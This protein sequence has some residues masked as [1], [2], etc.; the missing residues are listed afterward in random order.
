MNIGEILTTVPNA[1]TYDAYARL[2]N[3]LK[4]YKSPLC[5]ISGGSDSDIMLHLCATLDDEK[6][7]RYVFFDTG[8]EFQATKDHIKD[9]E[10]RYG[11]TIETH[12]AKMPVPLCTKKYGV[13]FLSKR[14]SDYIERLQRHN[15]Q[16]ED[17]DFETLYARY[18]K[19]KAPLRWWCNAFGENS[20]FNISHNKWLKEFMV[21]N[22]PTFAISNKCC[23]YAKKETAQD[24][25]KESDADL[26]IVGIRKSE[27]GARAVA[28]K[29]CYSPETEKHI[30]EFRPIFWFKNETKEAFKQC[31]EIKNSDCYEKW[32]LRRTGCSGCPFARDIETEINAVKMYE[33]KLYKA[34]MNVFGASYEYTKAYRQFQKEKQN[35]QS[36]SA[37]SPD[38]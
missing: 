7:I 26:N 17:E 22:P 19:C 3:K 9:L 11:I 5:S 32:G 1:E 27:G 38:S 10:Q 16:W 31:Y 8:L 12:R 15:F 33:P 34:L 37:G 28:Y 35:E 6:K 4:K 13:P 36:D 2:Y 18:P 23:K 20:R 24:C 14:V 25:I 30:A 29:S 21:E